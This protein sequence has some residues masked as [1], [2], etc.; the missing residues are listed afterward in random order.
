M[1]NQKLNIKKNNESSE[2]VCHR[3]TKKRKFHKSVKK[4]S[5]TGE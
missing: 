3:R 1:N 5:K 4:M 2:S